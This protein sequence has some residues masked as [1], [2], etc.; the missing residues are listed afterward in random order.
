MDDA[1]LE[2]ELDHPSVFN[3]KHYLYKDANV[4]DKYGVK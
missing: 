2:L 1:K 3:P 4:R